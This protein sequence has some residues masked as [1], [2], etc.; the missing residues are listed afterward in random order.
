MPSEPSSRSQ[1]IPRQ[2]RA[3]EVS[4]GHQPSIDSR[5]PPAREAIRVDTL[6]GRKARHLQKIRRWYARVVGSEAVSSDDQSLILWAES[7]DEARNFLERTGRSKDFLG[8][9]KIF[10]AKRTG[11]TRTNRY[12]G[13]DYYPTTND[14]TVDVY[15]EVVTAPPRIIDLVQWCTCDVMISRGQEPLLVLEDTTHIVRMNLYQRFPRLARAASL[16]VPS[17]ILQGTRGLEFRL[18]GDRWALYRYLQAMEAIARVHPESPTLAFW[19]GP[20]DEAEF[21]AERAAFQYV[22]SVING[23]ADDAD[24]ITRK[25]TAEVRS[26]LASGVEGDIARDLPCIDYTGEEVIVRVGARPD[27]KSWKEKGSGQMDPYVGLILAAKYIHCYDSSG[28][29]IKDLVLEFTYLP[30]DFWFF[31]DADTTALYKRLPIEFADQ[32]R[33]LG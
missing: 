13:G 11:K 4:I 21:D 14:E 24:L 1:L 9:D 20:A 7:P 6:R 16:G 10:V 32:V 17:L 5:L 19:Y 30:P 22:N 26:V 31:A 28:K 15:N 33:F 23:S 2:V 12:I 25:M 18:R 8:F 3:A 29:K 27:R